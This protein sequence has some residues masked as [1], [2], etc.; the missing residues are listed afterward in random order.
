MHFIYV[1]VGIFIILTPLVFSH[2]SKKKK[3]ELLSLISLT[4]IF[5]AGCSSLNLPGKESSSDSVSQENIQATNSELAELSYKGTQTIDINQGKPTFTQK[6]L[7][8]KNGPWEKY[9][10]LD[11]LNRPTYA[12]AL[13]KKSLMPT[14][15]RE[16]LTVDPTGWRNK[17]I[18]DGY[19]YNRSHL[20]GFQLT[21]QNNNLKNLITGTRQLNSPEM[22]RFE[23]DIAYF[24]K[25]NPTKYVRYSVVP[26]FNGEELVARGV[27]MQAQSI[28]SDDI[29]FNVYIFNIQDGVTINYSDG[30]SRIGSSTTSTTES[31]SEEK[32]FVD[33]NGN[34]LIKG[35][36]S[37]IYHIPGSKYYDKTTNPKAWFK[38][39][40]EAK[41]AGYRPPAE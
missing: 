37:G 18:K 28:D 14:E 2:L 29:Q 13:L 19:L 15:K 1:I 22:L 33:K 31:V 6:D 9:G 16:P 40:A 11:S 41:A 30:T 21:G 5:L 23:S 12:E 34:G 38:T 39:I 20:I 36:N 32:K 24:L 26:V 3:Y 35:S 25:E 8:T 27:H 4:A 7:T 17:K 10:D